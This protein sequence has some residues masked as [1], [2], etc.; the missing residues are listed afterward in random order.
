MVVGTLL[1]NKLMK[2][3]SIV[4]SRRFKIILHSHRIWYA[5]FVI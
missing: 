3:D 4:G 1:L 2:Q 5:V